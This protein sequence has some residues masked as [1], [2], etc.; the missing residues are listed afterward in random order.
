[1]A[2][3]IINVTTEE[4]LREA[5]D[6]RKEVFVIEQKVPLDI[7]IDELDSLDADAHH[8]LIKY[9]GE[10]AATGRVTYYNKDSAKMQRIAV[11]KPFRSKGL[12]RVLLMAMETQARE[13]KLLHSVLDAQCQAEA[14]YSKLG[15]VTISD[16]PFDDAGI[17]HVRMK[18]QLQ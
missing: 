15:Y 2:A 8:I 18:K 14:F 17:P 7:E 1:M 5:L 13:L 4:Q 16:E 10:Y 6:I 9:E 3:E 11:R 12:G